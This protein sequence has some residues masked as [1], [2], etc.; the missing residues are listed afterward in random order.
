MADILT[1]REVE[2]VSKATSLAEAG[3]GSRLRDLVHED[4]DFAHHTAI[5]DAMLNVNKEHIHTLELHERATGKPATEH[6]GNLKL[7]LAK[8]TV[9][10]QD[11]ITRQLS[12]DGRAIYRE[13]WNDTKKSWQDS[14]STPRPSGIIPPFIRKIN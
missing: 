8:K 6:I 5:I 4:K 11:F 12:S 14:G 7:D 10:G 3:N 2:D 13:I 1:P 9:D